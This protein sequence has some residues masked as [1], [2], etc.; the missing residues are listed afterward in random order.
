MRQVIFKESHRKSVIKTRRHIGM[1]EV[2]TY[3][4][5]LLY[6]THWAPGSVSVM[7]LTVVNV[8]EEPETT[9]AG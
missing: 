6:T 9:L 4:Y 8:G 3:I 5:S 7:E 2:G 1:Q